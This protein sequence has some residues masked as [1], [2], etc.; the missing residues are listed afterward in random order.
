MNGK[1]N[2]RLVEPVDL[3]EVTHSKVDD[4]RPTFEWVTPRELRVDESYQRN[5][6]RRSKVLIRQIIACWDWRRFKPPIVAETGEGLEIIDGQ[7]TAIAAAMHPGIEKIPVMLVKAPE[8]H[9]RAGAFLGH[10]RERISI[11]STQMF[12][13]AKIAQDPV[14]IN[15][16][17]VCER[18][19]VE[20]L[21]SP[22][23]GG[24]FREGQTLAVSAIMRLIARRGSVQAEYALAA[25]REACPEAVSAAAI[26]AVESLLF[27]PEFEGQITPA[28]IA[29]TLS[30]MGPSA[31]R[32]AK[33][34]AAT[35]KVPFWRGL[36]AVIFQNRRK[37]GRPA[38]AASA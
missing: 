10:N 9:T 33:F 21:R 20:I 13:A 37:G 23:A 35:H 34:F 7:H 8:Q 1:S 4:E 27:E 29:T 30:A 22:P 31:E 32:E 28:E 18:A 11:T 16:Q 26:R 15:A 25:A 3:G 38:V 6:S 12:F 17:A 14:A 36:A 24:K 19:G 2:T 5:L